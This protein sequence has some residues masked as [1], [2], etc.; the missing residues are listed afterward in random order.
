MRNKEV[1]I[2][3]PQKA[4]ASKIAYVTEDRHSGMVM[5]LSILENI[6]LASLKQFVNKILIDDRKREESAMTFKNRLA[7]KAPSLG[8]VVN[9][10]SGG[11]QQK[12]IFAKVADARC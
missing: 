10:L 9:N 11:N 2:D 1:K 6:T 4:I 7:I 5:H 3:C 12:V 8:T